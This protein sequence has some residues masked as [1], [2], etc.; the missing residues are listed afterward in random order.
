MLS[1]RGVCAAVDEESGDLT[2]M[3]VEDGEIQLGDRVRGNLS[4]IGQVEVLNVTQNKKLRVTIDDWGCGRI[5]ALD[6]VRGINSPGKVWYAR[7]YP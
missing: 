6:R 4:A 5:R 2:V 7:G 1:D 3:I